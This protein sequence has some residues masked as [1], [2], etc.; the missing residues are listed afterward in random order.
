MEISQN[1]FNE[2]YMCININHNYS[3]L[4]LTSVQPE[5]TESTQYKDSGFIR[6]INDCA[7]CDPTWPHVKR[8][9]SFQPPQKKENNCY[10][11][12]SERIIMV[13]VYITNTR[14]LCDRKSP[15][16]LNAMYHIAAKWCTICVYN[17]NQDECTIMDAGTRSTRFML[18]NSVWHRY[19]IW[20]VQMIGRWILLHSRRTYW[21]SFVFT[22]HLKDM[23]AFHNDV[24]LEKYWFGKLFMW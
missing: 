8:N 11:L 9:I 7:S 18:C 21:Q 10:Y 2:V 13:F 24:D 4:S 19:I 5:T 22:T 16:Q 14:K 20:I 17:N 15:K 23:H 6:V 1:V 3:I 12:K